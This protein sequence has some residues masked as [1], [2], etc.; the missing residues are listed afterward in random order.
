VTWRRQRQNIER[1]KPYENNAGGGYRRQKRQSWRISEKI[2]EAAKTV[3]AKATAAETHRL[4][5]RNEN[6]KRRGGVNINGAGEKRRS[7]SR[8]WRRK[9][10]RRNSW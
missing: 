3:A 2:I 9:S 4:K 5:S 10:A 1:R 6:S 8:R 7:A